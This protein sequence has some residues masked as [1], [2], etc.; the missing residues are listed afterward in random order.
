[1]HITRIADRMT[2]TKFHQRQE[3]LALSV[4]NVVA[5]LFGGIPATAALART[6]LNVKSGATCRMS[7]IISSIS[8]IVLSLIFLPYFKFLPLPN[9]AA[10]L[11]NVAI[12]MFEI[13]EIIQIYTNKVRIAPCVLPF[14]PFCWSHTGWPNET[15]RQRHFMI[16]LIVTVTCVFVEPTAGIITGILLSLGKGAF[17]ESKAWVLCKLRKGDTVLAQFHCYLVLP[18]PKAPDCR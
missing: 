17:L 10:I 6:A 4:A 11:V 1:M 16:M 12:H 13:E 15:L 8:V 9:V 3:V 2:K 18:R 5:G 14:W 7:G